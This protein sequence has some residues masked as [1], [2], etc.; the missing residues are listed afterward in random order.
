[1]DENISPYSNAI[2]IE[3]VM[4]SNKKIETLDSREVNSLSLPLK[5]NPRVKQL[6]RK[7]RYAFN[8]EGAYIS[9][10]TVYI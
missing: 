3:N 5:E 8:D 1:M 4:F 7:E 6:A 9:K 10:Q 2:D